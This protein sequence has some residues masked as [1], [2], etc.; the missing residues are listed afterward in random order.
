[1]L[2]EQHQLEGGRSMSLG[3]WGERKLLLALASAISAF[4]ASR[5][6]IP[7]A[8]IL[9]FLSP[10][11]TWIVGE[12][13]VDAVKTLKNPPVGPNPDDVAAGYADPKIPKK[14]FITTPHE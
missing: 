12:T 2:G 1:M 13:A 3:K 11:I 6:G 7:A 10:I 8:D 14:G 9:A 5:F 4:V